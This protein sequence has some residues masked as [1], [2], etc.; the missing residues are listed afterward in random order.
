MLII[1]KL[2]ENRKWRVE[3]HSLSITKKSASL[4]SG[5]FENYFSGN[6]YTVNS[7][8]TNEDFM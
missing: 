5:S 1:L 3:I 6:A 4:V 2:I 7:I 8:F